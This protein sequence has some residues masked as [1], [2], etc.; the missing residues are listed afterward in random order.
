MS[1]S[2]T[3]RARQSRGYY[4][5]SALVA[6]TLHIYKMRQ[7][8]IHASYARAQHLL[9]LLL[10]LLLRL[11]LLHSSTQPCESHPR[12]SKRATVTKPLGHSV[13]PRAGALPVQDIVVLYS[14]ARQELHFKSTRWVRCTQRRQHPLRGADCSAGLT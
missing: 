13:Y 11:L 1:L 5:A 14:L 10:L 7:T 3:C 12:W 9:L 8:L 4:A 2:H 6:S